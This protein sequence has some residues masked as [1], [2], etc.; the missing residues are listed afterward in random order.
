MSALCPS[1]GEDLPSVSGSHSLAETVLLLSLELFGL[2]GSE[3]FS[4]SFQQ[5]GSQ[6]CLGATLQDISIPYF[7]FPCQ[8]FF[9]DRIMAPVPASPGEVGTALAHSPPLP[10]H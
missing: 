9:A 6:A 1:A 10:P 3:H 7:P 2:I 5:T 4:P 8:S